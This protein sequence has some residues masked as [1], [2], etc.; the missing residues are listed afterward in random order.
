MRVPPSLYLEGVCLDYDHPGPW[1]VWDVRVQ[2]AVLANTSADLQT[3]V[4]SSKS[5]DLVPMHVPSELPT[6]P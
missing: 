4:N 1:R 2:A 5:V 6:S 3:P